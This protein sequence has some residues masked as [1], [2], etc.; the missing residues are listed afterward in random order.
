MKI[1]VVGLGLMGGSFCLALRRAEYEVD[2]Y[3][4]NE[5]TR[6]YALNNGFISKIP[7]DVNDLSAYDLVIVALPLNATLDFYDKTAF[8]KGALVTDICGVKKPIEAH[9]CLNE[10][11][12][13]YVG[14]HPM[15]GK[16]KSGI[17]YA[18]AT[19]FDGKNMV[20]TYNDETDEGALAAMCELS[21]ELGFKRI[22]KCTAD[23]HDKKI[24]YTSQLAHIVSNAY[25]KDNELKNCA[26]F[27]GGSFQDMTRIA[28]VDEKVWSELYLANA[29]NLSA[30]I[31]G[32]ISS[33]S[34][35]KDAIDGGNREN[36]ERL[37][38]EGREI[39]VS[40]EE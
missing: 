5:L 37:L 39:F 23:C 30:K 27:T 24:A 7:A 35:L 25:V 15:T 20:L 11:T 4:K 10:R 1:C 34:Q 40:N 36:L 19:L 3:D 33:L 17:A 18:S 38:A 2:G 29:E 14:C 6:E 8:K 26:P 9:I 16:E 28:G 13:H 12:F 31:G 32:L 21:A 22:I